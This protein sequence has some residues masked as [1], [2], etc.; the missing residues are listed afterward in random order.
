[1]GAARLLRWQWSGYP[2]FHCGRA[3]LLVHGVAV[4]VFLAGNIVLVLALPRGAVVPAALGLAAMAVSLAVQGR[5]H[6][7]EATPVEPFTG[8]AN[9]VARILLEQW[10]TFPRFVLTGGWLRALRASAR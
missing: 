3:N 9:A 7:T 8:A 2:R 4:P 1:M 5:G 10:I 6:A